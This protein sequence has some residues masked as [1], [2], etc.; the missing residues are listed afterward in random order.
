MKKPSAFGRFVDLGSAGACSVAGYWTMVIGIYWRYPP[1]LVVG[2]G[3]WGSALFLAK[4][5]LAKNTNS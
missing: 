1:A 3:L 5:G 2:T 4:R